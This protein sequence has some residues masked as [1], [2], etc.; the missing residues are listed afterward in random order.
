[1]VNFDY[2]YI[3][4]F[5]NVQQIRKISKFIESN[6][7]SIE[8][9]KFKARD[10]KGNIKKN[11][12]T[13]VISWKKIK[14]KLEELESNIYEINLRNFGYLLTPFNNQSNAIFNI[15]NSKNKSEYDWHSDS[16]Q[17]PLF[18]C[19]LTVLV[20]LSEFYEGGEFLLNPGSPYIVPEFTQ[21]SILIF[22]SYI[23][24]KVNPVTKGVRK[25]L[26]LFC[27]GPRFI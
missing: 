24:H 12:H 21:G 10:L 8:Q 6:Y 5:F 23:N 3:K 26:T 7:D 25:T 2:W 9:E 22:K 19:K 13:L 1:M 27:N 4:D 14:D 16:S 17:N 15:Y 20:N 18:D 11:T